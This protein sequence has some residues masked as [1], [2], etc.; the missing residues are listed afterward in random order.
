MELWLDIYDTS[1]ARIGP[2]PLASLVAFKRTQKLSAG[3]S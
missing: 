3:G 1:G 2:G